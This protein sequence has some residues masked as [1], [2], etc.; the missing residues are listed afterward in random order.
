[1]VQPTEETIKQSLPKSKNEYF[2][3][4]SD[5]GS[6]L[7]DILE[8]L[9]SALQRRQTNQPLRCLGAAISTALQLISTSMNCFCFFFFYLFYFIQFF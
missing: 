9:S 8:S 3:A 5:C 2:S 7:G 6:R 1:L 4:L